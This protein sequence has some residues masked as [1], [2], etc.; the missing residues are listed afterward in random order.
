MSAECLFSIN[1]LLFSITACPNDVIPPHAGAP[2]QVLAAGSLRT[3]SGV[4]LSVTLQ[5]AQVDIKSG[6][7][8]SPPCQSLELPVGLGNR[9]SSLRRGWSLVNFSAQ[10]QPLLSLLGQTDITQRIPQKVVINV[11]PQK[12]DECTPMPLVLAAR[13]DR[14]DVVHQSLAAQQGRATRPLFSST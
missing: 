11:E 1:P 7:V 4:G 10:P 2:T 5:T 12:V 14:L 13:V 6:R 9:H 3:P 8:A